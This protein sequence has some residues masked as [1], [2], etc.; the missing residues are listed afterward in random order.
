MKDFALDSATGDIIIYNNDLE[1]VNGDELVRQKA[2]KLVGTN[3][4]EWFLNRN[5]GINFREFLVKNP[6]NEAQKYEIEQALKMLDETF[7]ITAFECS[8]EG[9]NSFI[10]FTAANENGETVSASATF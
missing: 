9:R 5:Q 2:E 7:N 8:A 6:N 1:M 10:N 4:G 3:K